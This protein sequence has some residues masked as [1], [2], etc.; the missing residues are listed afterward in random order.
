MTFTKATQWLHSQVQ[1]QHYHNLCSSPLCRHHRDQQ[2]Y[3][4]LLP[5]RAAFASAA[6]PPAPHYTLLPP[7]LCRVFLPLNCASLHRLERLIYVSHNEHSR[8]HDASLP[9]SCPNVYPLGTNEQDFATPPTGALCQCPCDPF[10]T[11]RRRKRPFGPRDAARPLSH[12]H[13]YGLHNADTS[14]RSTYP[15]PGATSAQITETNRQYAASLDEHRR[16]TTVAQEL[17]KQLLLAVDKTYL[18]IL[19]DVDFGF[20][21]VSCATMLHHLRSTYGRF[22][23]EELER[24]RA[25][26]PP[27]GILTNRWRVSGS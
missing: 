4:N 3:I 11:R 23:P 21:D 8:V 25:P 16:Y 20:A 5:P 15:R 18:Y 26:S 19:A 17:K 13:R 2:S 7:S 14:W 12:T 24:N 10:H 27:T 6:N 1:L 22:T 9:A